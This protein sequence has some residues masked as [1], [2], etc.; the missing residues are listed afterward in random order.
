MAAP[1]V[2]T[3]SPLAGAN[4]V[5]INVNPTITFAAGLTTSSVSVNTVFLTDLTN[6]ERVPVTTSYNSS[7]FTVTLTLY[8][9]LREN[10]P[11]RIL[12]VGTD[13]KVSTALT[14]ADTTELPVSLVI[15][16][17]TGDELY[18]IDTTVEKEAQSK[19]LEDGFIPRLITI[20]SIPEALKSV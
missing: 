15:E 6:N 13:L 14:S 20:K 7:T 18:D 1:S 9:L 5:F 17:T 2:S 16:F 19:T 10:T 8:G 3:S 4:D 11:Y 12:M